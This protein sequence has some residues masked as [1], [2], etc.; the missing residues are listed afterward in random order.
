MEIAKEAVSMIKNHDIVYIPSATVGLFM[1]QNIPDELKIRV[2]T[3]S[4]VIAEELRK[5]DNVSVIMLGGE[6]DDKGNCYDTIAVEK[7]ETVFR[8]F[9]TVLPF[10]LPWSHYLLLMRIK[11]P[12]ER[13]FYEIEA[14]EAAWSIRVLQR[15]YNSSLYEPLALSRDKEAVLK[16]ATEGNVI[17]KPADI[18][19]QPTVLEFLGLEE[20]ASYSYLSVFP[21]SRYASSPATSSIASNLDFISV[22]S[23]F[24]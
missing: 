23:I 14:A 12:D 20:R 2:V 17:T 8:E 5:K 10:S 18:V 24:L 6:M 11:N 1:I 13:R 19:K 21:A 22:W 3:N 15:Q 7:S 4:I 9:E 16:L